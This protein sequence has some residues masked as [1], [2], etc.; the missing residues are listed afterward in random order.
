M[1]TDCR[2]RSWRRHVCTGI[3]L[4]TVL[5]VF[6]VHGQDEEEAAPAA[7]PG[8][9]ELLA[10]EAVEAGLRL[11]SSGEIEAIGAVSQEDGR[12]LILLS[13]HRCDVLP[14]EME[15]SEGPF[16]RIEIEVS[17][18]GG[19]ARTFILVTPRRPGRFRLHKAGTA[20]WFV[21]SDVDVARLPVREVES[22]DDAG[23]SSTSTGT[24]S[25]RLRVIEGV[26]IRSGPGTSFARL[27][28]VGPDHL[29]EE[30][31]REG[32]WV[33]VRS[34]EN[35]GWVHGDYLEVVESAAPEVVE[36]VP[37]EVVEP[38][39]PE[40]V[41][42]APPEVVE[43]EFPEAVESA[44]ETPEPPSAVAGPRLRVVE[45]VNVRSGPGTSFA[46]LGF[47]GPENLVDEL[48]REGDWVYVRYSDGEGWVH[49]DYLEPVPE[50]SR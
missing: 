36:P 20:A 34:S 31:E 23:A 8:A 39:P 7:P 11:Q 27:G 47:V 32:G 21:G 29:V 16:E 18:D 35:E 19:T 44:P 46:R 33:Y 6:P 50:P 24:D 10:V 45:G 28:F 26:N 49:G 13:N 14:A 15:F 5:A 43:P 2:N 48:K 41:E 17:D 40:V 4:Q 25:P 9:H 30:F 1:A 22:A 38:V 12:V 42:T 37:P 3:L